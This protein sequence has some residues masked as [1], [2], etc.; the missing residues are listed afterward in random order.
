MP[1][2]L[3]PILLDTLKIANISTEGPTKTATGGMAADTL[4]KYGKKFSV[5]MQDAL[6][7]ASTLQELYGANLSSNKQI[8]A[9]TDRF[10]GEK[11]LV[12]TT[13]VIDQA[14]GT[15]QPIKICIPIFN[16]DGI[17]NLTQDAE[18]DVST[19]DLN[20]Q[21][22]SFEKDSS[23]TVVNGKYTTGTDNSFYFMTTV[24]GMDAIKNQG[25]HA[26][27]N[28]DTT[29]YDSTT[30]KMKVKSSTGSVTQYYA[31]LEA[32]MA[33]FGVVT[34][35]NVE[36]YPAIRFKESVKQGSLITYK[37]QDSAGN[38]K[39]I[40]IIAEADYSAG[41]WDAVGTFL[42]YKQ[43]DRA[44][45]VYFNDGAFVK[46]ENVVNEGLAETYGYNVIDEATG[47]IIP[48]I[49]NTITANLF[50]G[51]EAIVQVVIP[52]EITGIGSNAFANSSIKS[53]IYKGTGEEWNGVECREGWNSGITATVEFEG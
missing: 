3:K 46:W 49:T 44:A 25:Y 20:G 17:F 15:K 31:S 14:T 39:E 23:G 6:G 48:P 33:K 41:D 29:Y 36:I 52:K 10:P 2:Y 22:V 34:V 5:E 51:C 16:C 4:L 27:W 11:T 1:N 30:K 38:A 47:T 7:H 42:L 53:I 50:S 35:M 13:F 32:M 40:K 12:G 24:D 19:F 28:D 18:G 21:V 26:V 43:Q 8:L 45:G 37:G 9:I